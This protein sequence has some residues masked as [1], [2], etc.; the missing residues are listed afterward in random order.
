MDKVQDYKRRFLHIADAPFASW[1]MIRG[2]P[3]QWVIYQRPSGLIQERFGF[4]DHA[5]RAFYNL[6]GWRD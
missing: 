2:N 3:V 1:G 5:E 6:Y 4:R